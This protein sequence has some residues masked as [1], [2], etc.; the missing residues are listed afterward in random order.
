MNKDLEILDKKQNNIRKQLQQAQNQ[1][2]ARLIKAPK[3]LPFM[4]DS[5]GND[6]LTTSHGLQEI[7]QIMMEQKPQLEV[8]SLA[9]AYM[10]GILTVKPGDTYYSPND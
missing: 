4:V 5:D 9:R 8:K 10:D 6:L 1:E 7:S 2:L 3:G